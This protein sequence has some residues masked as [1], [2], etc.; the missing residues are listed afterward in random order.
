MLR[1]NIQSAFSWH[2][3]IAY[4][5]LFNIAIILWYV[6]ASEYIN[7][8][9]ITSG[10][11]HLIVGLVPF[12]VVYPCNKMI[13]LYCPDS[14]LWHVF[15]PPHWKWYFYAYIWNFGSHMICVYENFLTAVTFSYIEALHANWMLSKFYRV[16]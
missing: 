9:D 3:L 4:F 8:D 16:I 1:A 15:F 7:E 11:K 12:R 10:W 5:C 6:W 14:L 2:R 13:R